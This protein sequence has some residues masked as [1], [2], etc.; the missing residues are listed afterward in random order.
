M[1]GGGS[2][3][4]G[5]CAAAAAT[6]AALAAA[7]A[8]MAA[9]AAAAQTAAAAAAAAAV[10]AAEAAAATAARSAAAAEAAAAAAIAA[11]AEAAEATRAVRAAA[12]LCGRRDVR[13]GDCG[14]RARPPMAC[15]RHGGPARRRRRRPG[16]ACEAAA[17][18]AGHT[19]WRHTRGARC[20]RLPVR[21]RASGDAATR[22]A[23]GA[24]AG[25]AGGVAGAGGAATLVGPR[26]ALA[27]AAAPVLSRGSAGQRIARAASSAS[28]PVA[29]AHEEHSVPATAAWNWDLRPL[30]HGLPAVTLQ[31]SGRDGV[32]PATGIAL[33]EVEQLRHEGLAM[34][35]FTDEGIVSEMLSG[36]EDDSRCRRGTLLCAPHSGALRLL[37]VAQQKLAANV[38]NGWSSSGHALPCWPLRSCPYSIVDES[39][40]AGKPKF[41]LTTDLSWP[42]PGALEVDGVCIDAVNSAMDRSAWPT[43]RLL[44]VHEFAEAAAVLQGPRG[45][46]RRV[47]L[48]SLDGTAFYRE[49]GRQRAELWRN[50]VWLPDGAQLDERCCFGDASAATKCARISNF[51]VWQMRIAMPMAAVDAAY[52]CID[53]EWLEW[54]AARRAAGVGGGLSWLGMYVDDA[55]GASADDLLWR[56]DGTAALDADGQHCRRAQAHFEAARGVLVRFGWGSEASKERPPTEVLE[57]LGAELHLVEERLRLSQPKRRRY[58]E[59]ARA[60]AAEV[61]CDRRDYMRL[62]GR[63]TS[64]V[65]CYPI[66]RQ[67]LHAAWRVARTRFRLTDG[68]VPV[69]KAVRRDLIWWAMEL[70]REGHEGVPLA[71][72]GER[73]QSYIYADASGEQGWMAWAVVGSELLF[74]EGEWTE[75]ERRSLIICEKELLASTWGLVALQPFLQQTVVSYTDNTVAQAAMRSMAPGSAAMQEL[76]ARRT[77]FLYEHEVME[78]AR[79]I[80]S[81]ANLWA[82]LGSRR[83]LADALRQAEQLGLSARRVHVPCAWRDSTELCEI[84]LADH[85]GPPPARA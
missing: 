3:G 34:H 63:L 33:G 59:H 41:R 45:A 65:Q 51:L 2:S 19:E 69:T 25:A 35:G 56:A 73:E 7:P 74:V 40:R 81:K 32:E 4:S 67:H 55:M 18:A 17:S 16:T 82:D 20:A 64:A 42:H 75:R 60:V 26:H 50:A 53:P 8:A 47:R 79:R 23:A 78:Q 68:S 52:P 9:A 85:G 27:A 77:Q 5:V 48:W 30:E 43:N 70:E 38:A 24:G 39:V 1:A 44:R 71:A 66:G 28:G 12:E 31:V 61:R 80:T 22:A 21:E 13:R 14:R 37:A 29:A 46:H 72:A 62:I 84:A 49:V 54:Q 6:T 10:A 15:E 76:T 11:A 57:A 36:I 58:A 83:R